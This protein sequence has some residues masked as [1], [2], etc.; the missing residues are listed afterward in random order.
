M[1]KKFLVKESLTRFREKEDE[2]MHT[3]VV[4]AGDHDAQVVLSTWTMMPLE[5][6]VPRTNPPS[7]ERELWDWLWTS[8]R[9]NWSQF[10][11]R[12]GMNLSRLQKV[13]EPLRSNRLLYPDGTIPEHVKGVLT[14]EVLKAMKASTRKK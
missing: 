5:S 6:V 9:I 2:F 7:E 11:E 13:F 1:D 14:S 8:V 10:S 12:T 3:A 4:L